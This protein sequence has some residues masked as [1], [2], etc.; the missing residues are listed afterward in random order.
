LAFISWNCILSS[1]LFRDCL[2]LDGLCVVGFC[3]RGLCVV[4]FLV[5]GSGV[6]GF[7]VTI[8]FN[9]RVGGRRVLT[10]GAR[11]AASVVT[12]EFLYSSHLLAH[13]HN[14]HLTPVVSVSVSC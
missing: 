1:T 5:V 8:G 14:N 4:G 10:S 2:G 11:V 3:V 7:G 12:V 13:S 9:R 6:V